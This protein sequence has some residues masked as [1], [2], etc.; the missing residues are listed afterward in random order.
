[1][2]DLSLS[3]LIIQCG[4]N[5][6]S[7]KIE[8]PMSSYR[9]ARERLVTMDQLCTQALKRSDIT[10]DFFPPYTVWH[11]LWFTFCIFIW[12]SFLR[13]TNFSQHGLFSPL[14]PQAFREFC[15]FM[16]PIVWWG[17]TGAHV[18]ETYAFVNGRLKRHGVV[19]VKSFVFWQWFG[20]VL[21]QGFVAYMR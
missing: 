4:T 13:K 21:V 20:D 1:M 18:F 16:Q 19:N 10:I 9:D 3:E 14:L 8:P 5:K 12:L 2:I 7:T 11:R 6:Y 17:M 15:Y